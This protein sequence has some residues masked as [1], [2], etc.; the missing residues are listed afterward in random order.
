MTCGLWLKVLEAP[1]VAKQPLLAKVP[2]CRTV[3]V[4][5]F[6][7]DRGAFGEGVRRAL[8]N[9]RDGTGVGPTP[10]DCLLWAGHT[11]VS[12]DSDPAI[13]YGFNPNIG[14]TPLWQAMQQ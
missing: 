3:T 11:G 13:I 7:G 4:Y 6:R 5:T 1:L 9:Q 8:D 10:T 2:K 12:I 14:K